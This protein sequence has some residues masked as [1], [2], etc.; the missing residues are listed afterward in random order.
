MWSMVFPRARFSECYQQTKHDLNSTIGVRR[1]QEFDLI[2]F[3]PCFGLFVL[4]QLQ[5]RRPKDRFSFN[6]FNSISI[7]RSMREFEIQIYALTFKCGS[8]SASRKI[9]PRKNIC[10]VRREKISLSS[11]S[12][13]SQANKMLQVF[14]INKRILY[15]LIT[16]CFLDQIYSNVSECFLRA[17]REI[18]TPEHSLSH[19]HIS[20]Y[21]AVCANGIGA[22]GSL[23]WCRLQA[24]GARSAYILHLH[25]H[26]RR[27]A[28]KENL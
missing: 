14:K 25:C 16:S 22:L 15:D 21:R 13:S 18:K 12:E 10:A 8:A 9:M 11:P 3:P 26:R 28:H 4:L 7:A 17:R 2:S 20:L 19:S 6:K 23:F 1:F 27:E 24:H 5:Y